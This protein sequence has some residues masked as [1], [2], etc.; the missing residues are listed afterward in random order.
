MSRAS[1]VLSVSCS[2]LLIASSLFIFGPFDIYLANINEYSLPLEALLINLLGFFVLCLGVSICAAIVVPS[3][4]RSVFISFVFVIAIAVYLQGNMLFISYGHLDGTDI[5]FTKFTARNW[6]ELPVWAGLILAGI[7][8]HKKVSQQATFISIV[9]ILIVSASCIVRY[10]E[11]SDE[12][13]AKLPLSD[14]GVDNTLF[15]LSPTFNVIHILL[16]QLQ[17]DVA[18]NI[19]ADKSFQRDVDDFVFYKENI[20]A[21]PVT[22]FSLPALLSGQAYDNTSPMREFI[23]NAMENDAYYKELH[24]QGYAID[25]LTQKNFLPSNF[26][27]DGRVICEDSISP[28]DSS[29]ADS[30]RVAYKL[31]DYSL[32]RYALI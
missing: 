16:D 8:F 15:E 17:S 22:Q 24:R 25:L 14:A 30:K 13:N 23:D 19:L 26:C 1:C 31:A 12:F 9:I 6:I 21:F 18:F 3:A 5:D 27:K 29:L 2:G 7:V 20:G 28:L 10:I 11:R 4:L 32:F